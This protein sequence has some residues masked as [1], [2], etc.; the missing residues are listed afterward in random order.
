MDKITN[1]LSIPE[2]KAIA[3][4]EENVLLKLA[5]ENNNASVAE[6]LMAL[7]KVKAKYDV[8]LVIL[9]VV[10]LA[11]EREEISDY[12][13]R[14]SAQ[15]IVMKMDVPQK[16]QQLLSYYPLGSPVFRGIEDL[17]LVLSKRYLADPC[18]ITKDNGDVIEL[19]L[20]W[21]EFKLL[22]LN[23]DETKRALGEYFK[24]TNHIAW[25]F[26][27]IKNPWMDPEAPGATQ[28]TDYNV[29]EDTIERLWSAVND[30]RH[31]PLEGVTLE[32]RVKRFIE[33]IADMGRSNNSNASQFDNPSCIAGMP[34]HLYLAVMS[35]P[36]YV[37]VTERDIKNEFNSYLIA[38]FNGK[39][40]EQNRDGVIKAYKNAISG[41][42]EVSD[43]KCF[44][45]LDITSEEE[46][47]FVEIIKIKYG[48]PYVNSDE[49]KK[50][51][52]I[53]L[54]LN[55]LH[56][57]HFLKHLPTLQS[58]FAVYVHEMLNS[59]MAEVI[60]NK[61]NVGNQEGI[62]KSY[63]HLLDEDAHALTEDDYASLS[64]LDLTTE[65]VDSFV[66]KVKEKYGDSYVECDDFKKI[67]AM[68]LPAK[69]GEGIAHFKKY[70]VPLKQLVPAL[71]ERVS[72]QKSQEYR[73][74]L[75][76][77]TKGESETDPHTPAL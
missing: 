27:H 30:P 72:M 59:H 76:S 14:E 6:L 24:N 15:E 29:Y 26:L 51:L 58:L 64:T 12:F 52:E 47:A 19:P 70:S 17:R 1:L 55:T 37:V 69:G 2:L 61:I 4:S 10:S 22:G 31:P 39:I 21:D 28:K 56:S 18:K 44:S 74:S 9:P 75:S 11:D 54:K 63:K 48:E 34:G 45:S 49:F 23:S 42:I 62:I 38:L 53:Q 13:G 57:S 41:D 68:Y 20:K 25:R 35:H 60:G 65:E 73:E 7:P 32:E 3:H 50:I 8:A 43:Y 33:R 36:L 77:Q 5:R 67:L 46:S 71:E 16:L 40:N 66:E